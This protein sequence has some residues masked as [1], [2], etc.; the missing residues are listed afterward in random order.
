MLWDRTTW[1][2]RGLLVAFLLTLLMGAAAASAF[3]RV[4]VGAPEPLR[5]PPLQV[6]ASGTYVL[7]AGQNTVGVLALEVRAADPLVAKDGSHHRGYQLRANA[8]SGTEERHHTEWLLP[9]GTMVRHDIGELRP[10][11]EE[12]RVRYA[13]GE[14]L[15]PHLDL[16]GSILQEGPYPE[17]APS[18]RTWWSVEDGRAVLERMPCATVASDVVPGLIDGKDARGVRIALVCDGS[19]RVRTTWFTAQRSL[20]Q[21]IT[22]ERAAGGSVIMALD[23]FRPGSG[24]DVTGG[25]EGRSAGPPLRFGPEGHP[26]PVSGGVM[27]LPYPIE[28]AIEDVAG[29]A[30]SALFRIWRTQHPDADLVGARL[31]RGEHHERERPTDQWRLLYADP[32]GEAYVVGAERARGGNGM[33]VSEGGARQVTLSS[34]GE[35]PLRFITL[36]VAAERWAR[37]AGPDHEGRAPDFVHWGLDVPLTWSDSCGFVPAQTALLPLESRYDRVVIGHS[38]YGSCTDPKVVRS[39]SYAVLDAGS[40][41]AHEL[42]EHRVEL[43]A[44]PTGEVG[45]VTPSSIVTAVPAISFRP[46]HV[47]PFAAVTVPLLVLIWTV[48]FWPNLKLFVLWAY[49]RVLPSAVPDHPVRARLLRMVCED[50]G[51]TASELTARLGI[52]WGAF[53]HHTVLLEKAGHLKSCT[54]G[55]SRHLFTAHAARNKPIRAV[56]LLRHPAAQAALEAVVVKPG[57]SQQE[58]A[59]RLGVTPAGALWHARRLEDAGLVRRERIGRYV[60]YHPAGGSDERQ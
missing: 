50:E 47:E 17:D 60:V 57:L 25:A 42:V 14:P 26:H 8:T 15:V 7:F 24:G 1:R 35:H 59:E 38:T 4:E 51:I 9:D 48:Y 30:G 19:E 44:F 3:V 10:G 41:E 11:F 34:G 2:R 33:W 58:L 49:S 43:A 56:A 5:A 46:P 36:Q 29:P 23:S 12:V 37:L 13:E 32:D 28:R 20:P 39:E 45:R 27:S 21:V 40:G 52:G 22:Y 55:R 54:I 31:M 6:G 16:A 53:T 18:Q